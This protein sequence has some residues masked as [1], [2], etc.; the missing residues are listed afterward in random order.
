MT[1]RKAWIDLKEE[2][3]AKSFSNWD[4]CIEKVRAEFKSIMPDDEKYFS[5]N[6][7]LRS[8]GSAPSTWDLMKALALAK[9]QHNGKMMFYAAGHELCWLKTL[10][11]KKARLLDMKAYQNLKPN[12]RKR[13]AQDEVNDEYGDDKG[14]SQLD[15]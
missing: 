10:I 15:I 9:H 6:W 8:T 14:L 3:K 4:E 5:D 11:G 7:W 2:S 13:E 12:K 1:V